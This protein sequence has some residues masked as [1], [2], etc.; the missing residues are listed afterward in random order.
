[1]QNTTNVNLDKVIN[2]FNKF[3]FLEDFINMNLKFYLNQ[4]KAENEFKN[5]HN[6]L[7]SE[8]YKKVFEVN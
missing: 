7:Y 6:I 5:K 3:P 4:E 1:M 2:F 8:V